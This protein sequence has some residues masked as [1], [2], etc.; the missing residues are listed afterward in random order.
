V[1][2]RRGGEVLAPG[3]GTT[4]IQVIDGRDLTAFEVL[5]MERRTGGT[6]D[7][8]GPPPAT[9]LTMKAYLETCRQAAG[10]DA[11]FVWAD[12][13]FLDAN[14][15]GPW[16]DLP[17]WLPDDADYAGFGRRSVAKAVAAGLAYRPLAETVRDTLAWYD[18]LA[19]DK[20]EAVT[21]RAGLAPEREEAALKAWHALHG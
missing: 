19:A 15:I 17:C 7:V 8:T 13:A 10:S 12:T 18:G 2:V 9:P 6:F 16:R 21:K 1:R 3:D 14:G 5:C 4:A 11:S 20:R